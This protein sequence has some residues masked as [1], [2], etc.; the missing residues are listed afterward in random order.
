ML[1][2][3]SFKRKQKPST[4]KVSVSLTAFQNYNYTS[5]SD[6]YFLKYTNSPSGTTLKATDFP[7]S[8]FIS[9]SAI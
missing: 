7:T 4:I 2:I 8:C 1:I 6:V 9:F 3:Q 5:I